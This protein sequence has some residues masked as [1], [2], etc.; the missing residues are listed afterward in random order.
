VDESNFNL[1]QLNLRGAQLLSTRPGSADPCQNV[2][3]MRA[4]QGCPL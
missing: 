2:A 4:I 1:L 3:Y